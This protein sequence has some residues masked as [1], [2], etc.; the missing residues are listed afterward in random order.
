[1][2]QNLGLYLK[3]SSLQASNEAATA[4][5]VPVPSL[6][7]PAT[8]KHLKP[9]PHK[10]WSTASTQSTILKPTHHIVGELSTGDLFSTRHHTS[11]CLRVKL[12]GPLP[13]PPPL[14]TAS[15]RVSQT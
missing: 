15:R 5:Q 13:S 10:P 8:N 6:L 9:Q 11:F 12:F 7:R 4:S 2:A 14:A 3:L 1:M